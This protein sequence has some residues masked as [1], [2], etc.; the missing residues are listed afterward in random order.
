MINKTLTK[1]NNIFQ[2]KMKLFQ[3]I[4]LLFDF[5]NNIKDQYAIIY[6]KLSYVRLLQKIETFYSLKAK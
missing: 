4:I 6:L 5:E 1:I 2:S 3:V